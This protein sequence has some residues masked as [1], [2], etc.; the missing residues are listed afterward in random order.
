ML[1]LWIK[2][3]FPLPMAIISSDAVQNGY[4]QFKLLQAK[5]SADEA[6][7]TARALQAQAWDARRRADRADQNAQSLAIESDMA[8]ATAGKARQGL[9]AVQTA[10]QMQVQLTTATEQV[11][12]KQQGTESGP[13]TL[14]TPVVNVQGQLTG[15]VVNTTA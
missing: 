5:R 1:S 12:Q 3:C 13:S 10:A 8:Q 9:A 14:S 7:Q 15:T 6:E 11:V 4:Q 2:R